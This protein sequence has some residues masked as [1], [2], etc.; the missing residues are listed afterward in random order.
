LSPNNLQSY[1]LFQIYWS[2]TI[3][4][5]PT[6]L[7][8]SALPINLVDLFNSRNLID[9]LHYL[10]LKTNQSTKL[11]VSQY[12]KSMKACNISTTSSFF[13]STI[14]RDWS[15]SDDKHRSLTRNGWMQRR[16]SNLCF[17]LT[18]TNILSCSK[19]EIKLH[20]YI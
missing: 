15:D 14:T 19:N 13:M 18:I 1:H 3:F 16:G 2:I 10:K 17:V 11:W 20:K 4:L 8:L 9:S 5:D 6:L 12:S 7:S